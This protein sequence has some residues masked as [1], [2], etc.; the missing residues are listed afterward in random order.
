MRMRQVYGDGEVKALLSLKYPVVSLQKESR[1]KQK[2]KLQRSP[3]KTGV[4]D[5]SDERE[6]KRWRKV[7]LELYYE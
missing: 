5:I 2:K 3:S 4:T 6:R 1:I 7:S